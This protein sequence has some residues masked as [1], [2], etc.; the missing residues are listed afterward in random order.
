MSATQAPLCQRLGS[1]AAAPGQVPAAVTSIV[2]RQLELSRTAAAAG[3][4]EAP[5]AVLG[6]VWPGDPGGWAAFRDA[7]AAF[8]ADA[9]WADPIGA[10]IRTV[11]APAL[12][13]YG[14]DEPATALAVAA[15]ITCRLY[16]A[17]QAEMTAR[18]TPSYT[19][20]GPLGAAVAVARAGG[21]TAD[22]IAN[23]IAVAGS[24]ACGAS[25]VADSPAGAYLAG[26][27]A[28][29]GLLAGQL[30]MAGFT[31]PAS[32]LEGQRGLFKAF[33]GGWDSVAAPV[34]EGLG[35]D[36]L[37]ARVTGFGARLAVRRHGKQ[38]RAFPG[39]RASPRYD[40]PTRRTG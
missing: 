23:A 17:L 36:W 12:R 6:R 25:E 11:I 20:L 15:E 40:Q 4:Q 27:A 16:T 2:L 29:S 3:S 13:A 34:A 33:A 1:F 31:G 26:W 18:H 7:S 21:G 30:G 28:Q 35:A 8:S 10:T 9:I 32:A 24:L 14:G 37:L 19:V 5:A 39:T 38:E 22:Q